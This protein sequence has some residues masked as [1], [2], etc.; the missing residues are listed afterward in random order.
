MERSKT[1]KSQIRVDKRNSID[2]SVQSQNVKSLNYTKHRQM[3]SE[4]NEQDD[5]GSS[6]KDQP[7]K[8]NSPGKERKS[9]K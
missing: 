7:R 8:G 1:T 5:E 3:E 9:R 4:I 6:S 2:N